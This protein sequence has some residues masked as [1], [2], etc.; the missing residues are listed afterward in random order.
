[1]DSPSVMQESELALQRLA[2]GLRELTAMRSDLAQDVAAED[3]ALL[4]QQL[5]QLHGQWEEL[6]TKVSPGNPRGRGRTKRVKD[7]EKWG[8]RRRRGG[9]MPQSCLDGDQ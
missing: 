1:M 6:C 5:E 4:E 8:E 3:C 7:R 2:G 9:Q